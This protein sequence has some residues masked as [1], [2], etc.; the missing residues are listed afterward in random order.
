[1]EIMYLRQLSGLSLDLM[2]KNDI[3]FPINNI[4]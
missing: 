4:L 1:M 3:V 2:E